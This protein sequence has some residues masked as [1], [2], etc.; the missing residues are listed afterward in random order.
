MDTPMIDEQYIKQN[1]LMGDNL[2][3]KYLR[4]AIETAQIQHLQETIGT[5]LY[6]KLLNDLDA[7][8]LDEN[9]EELMDNYIRP[10][11]LHLVLADIIIPIQYKFRNAGMMGNTDERLQRSSLD[12]ANFLRQY[13]MDKAHFYGNRLFNYLVDNANL[14]KDFCTCKK[15][16]DLKANRFGGYESP[17]YLGK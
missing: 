8:I 7:D 13:Y 6:K 12:E 10:F 1:S 15:Y 11:L 16:T 9:E 14:F 4:A 3:G 5:Q 17:I 2:D